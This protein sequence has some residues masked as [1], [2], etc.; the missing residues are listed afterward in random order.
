MHFKRTFV[1]VTTAAALSLSSTAVAS[2]EGT[3]QAIQDEIAY[4]MTDGVSSG[5]SDDAQIAG[6]IV[7]SGVL[8]LGV[9][10]AMIAWLSHVF[11]DWKG[12]MNMQI[13]TPQEID[14]R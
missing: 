1:A 6:L 14:L 11:P 9:I 7:I 13:H 8:G 2:A 3:S 4:S 5:S 12:L 10:G